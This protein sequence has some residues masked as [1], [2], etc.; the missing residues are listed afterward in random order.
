MLLGFLNSTTAE[1]IIGLYNQ[2]INLMPDEVRRI[3]FLVPNYEL[4]DKV[5][6]LICYEKDD[7]NREE[8]SWDFQT[9]YMV[10]KTTH[11]LSVILSENMKAD[12]GI[13]RDEDKLRKGIE[14]VTYYLSIA[15]KI[16]FDTSEMPYLGFSLKAILTL[17]RATLT[18]AMFRQESRGAHIR[19]DHPETKEDWAVPTI[20]SYDDGAYNTR[21]DTEKEYES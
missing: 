10:S 14:D 6:K 2:T 7:W 5:D 15:D 21:L 20:I 18:C 17:A 19:S 1:F 16:R 9:H 12:L 4:I 8:T 3:P 11:L 13:V